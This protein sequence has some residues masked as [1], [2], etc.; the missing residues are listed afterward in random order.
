MLGN[1]A[2]SQM[3]TALIQLLKPDS[4]SELILLK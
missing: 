2:F 1:L 3:M 4:Q